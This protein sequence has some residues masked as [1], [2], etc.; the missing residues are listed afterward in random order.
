MITLT[1]TLGR[2]S[3]NKLSWKFNNSLL[4]DKLFAAEINAVIKAKL[5]ADEINAVIKAIVEEYASVPHTQ[6]Q[7]SDIP[8]CDIQFLSDQQ[9]F[10]CITNENQMKDDI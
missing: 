8:K 1:L 6:E 3:K 10:L 5:F 4:K 9:F 2:E 7:L